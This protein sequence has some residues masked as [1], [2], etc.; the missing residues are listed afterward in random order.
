[1]SGIVQFGTGRF[2]LGHVD[3][4]ISEALAAGRT[5]ERVLVVQSSRREEGRRKA[6]ALAGGQRYPVHLRGYRDGAMID[7][8]QVVESIDDC[9]I[10]AEQ[11]QALERHVIDRARIIVSNTA[12]RGFEVGHDSSLKPVPE[13][14]PGKL[15]KLLKA[16]FDAGRDGLTLLPCELIEANGAT[17]LAIVTGLARRDGHDEAFID[18]LTERCVWVD[19]LVDRIVSE[20][21]EPVG[22]V[23]EPYALWAIKRRPGMALPC[24]HPDV[25]VVDDLTP[26][27]LCKLHVLNLSHTFLV[28]LWRDRPGEVQFVREAMATPALREPLEAVLTDEVLPVLATRLPSEAL[29]RYRD[30]TLERFTNPFLDHRLADIADHHDAKRA[31]RLEPVIEMARQNGLAVPA[32]ERAAGVCL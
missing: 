17:L 4:L 14:F 18:W 5:G 15:V 10:A 31:R 25:E 20:P 1:M 7:R 32:L 16:R 8:E 24:A 12:D 13:S 28:N 9:L 23:A 11:W 29:Q 30:I 27:A 19:T 26:Q 3:A 2:L 6:Q 22:A 21:L